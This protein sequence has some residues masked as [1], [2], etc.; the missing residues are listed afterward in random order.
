MK[1]ILVMKMEIA[2]AEFTVEVWAT[3]KN[4]GCDDCMTSSNFDTFVKAEGEMAKLMV[5]TYFRNCAHF[6][7]EDQ[8]GNV[9]KEVVRKVNHNT[10][11]KIEIARTQGMEFGV[12]GYNEVM[13]YDAESMDDGNDNLVGHTL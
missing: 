11:W 1:Y 12:E 5:S 6:L 10:D 13:G 4:L 8:S 7:I 9:L 2:M 3:H